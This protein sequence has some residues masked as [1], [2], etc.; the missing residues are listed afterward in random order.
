MRLN[1][2]RG[3]EFR[4]QLRNDGIDALQRQNHVGVPVEEKIDLR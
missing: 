2:G 3:R 4:L 1:F